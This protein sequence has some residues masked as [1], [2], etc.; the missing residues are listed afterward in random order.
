MQKNAPMPV[1]DAVRAAQYV[2]MSADLQQYS[3]ENQKAAIQQYA[4]QH[5]FVVVRTYADAGESGVVLNRLG[6]L[7]TELLEDVIAA[8]PVTGNFG[9]RR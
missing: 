3:I 4:Q 5:G 9:V 8:I 6:A 7:R 2:R 1:C